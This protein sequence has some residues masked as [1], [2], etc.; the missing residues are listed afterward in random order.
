MKNKSNQSK[1]NHTRAEKNPEPLPKIKFAMAPLPTKIPKADKEETDQQVVYIP[2]SIMRYIKEEER[3]SFFYKLETIVR[4]LQIAGWQPGKDRPGHIEAKKI[5]ETLNSIHRRLL[6]VED[7][8]RDM[9]FFPWLIQQHANR[10]GDLDIARHFHDDLS[11]I[12]E[13]LGEELQN[14]TRLFY[15][16]GEV[17]AM[18]A[19]A[20]AEILEEYGIKMTLTIH[21]PWEKLTSIVIKA[22]TGNIIPFD[23]VQN[24]MRTVRCKFVEKI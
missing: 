9:D 12:I 17:P 7:L 20:V 13:L 15:T 18:V 5:R 6:K 21:A 8:I 23:S 10:P 19:E 14:K 24:A 4:G 22:A 3:R 1:I 2:R 16:R 11:R